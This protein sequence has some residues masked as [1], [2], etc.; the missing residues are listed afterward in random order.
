M[1]VRVHN[2]ENYTEIELSDMQRAQTGMYT[3]TAKNKNGEDSHTF[4]I[5]CICAPSKCE[6][7]VVSD[8]TK[9]GCHLNFD[10]PRD[11]GGM[12]ITG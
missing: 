2:K 6:N 10:P 4:E 12:P 9:N 11:N 5:V 1:N 3:V 8:V 7:L